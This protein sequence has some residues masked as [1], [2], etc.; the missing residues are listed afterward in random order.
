MWTAI[1]PDPKRRTVL[2]T[3]PEPGLSDT[4]EKI[5]ILGWRPIAAPMLTVEPRVLHVPHHAFTHV[6]LSSGQA[7]PAL[8]E[9]VPPHVSVLAVGEKTAARAREAGFTQVRA[10]DGDA[11]SLLRLLGAAPPGGTILLAV[12]EGQSL[13]MAAQARAQGW[14][15]TRRVAYVARPV[16]DV[17]PAARAALQRGEVEAVLLFSAVTAQSWLAALGRQ[18]AL[19]TPVRA[20]TLSARVAQAASAAHWRSVE[21]AA[22]PEQA[23]LLDV[24]GSCHI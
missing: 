24:L 21:T 5:K 12:G 4:I 2:V 20:V 6:L 19:L 13:E 3:R 15:V 16:R 18:A 8:S 1:I 10:A 9:A 22:R 11:C 23:A 7:V 14:R 17:P